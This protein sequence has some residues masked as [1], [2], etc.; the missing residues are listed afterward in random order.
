MYTNTYNINMEFN[1]LNGN[2]ITVTG[3]LWQALGKF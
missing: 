1:P 3:V 2:Y